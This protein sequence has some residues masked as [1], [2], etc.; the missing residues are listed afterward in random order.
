MQI[1]QRR[2]H[3][4]A[5]ARFPIWVKCAETGKSLQGHTTNVSAGGM[6]LLT[7]VDCQFSVGADVMVRFG[8]RDDDHGGYAVHE[9]A[10]GA[11]IVRLERHGYGMGIALKF[12]ES[13]FCRCEPEHTLA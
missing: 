2:L 12:T 4:R 9:A 13:R 6:Y 3:E 5:P 11:E 8:I 7:A 10:K 1:Q